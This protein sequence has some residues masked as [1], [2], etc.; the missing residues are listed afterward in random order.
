MEL[1]GVDWLW[2]Y[3]VEIW[4]P[5]E[6]R[7]FLRRFRGSSYVLIV[8]VRENRR[9]C[10]LEQAGGL[11]EDEDKTIDLS[12][13]AYTKTKVRGFS[14]DFIPAH[15]VL[16][17]GSE[18]ITLGLCNLNDNLLPLSTRGFRGYGD[19]FS[20]KR[21]SQQEKPEKFSGDD[22]T[23]IVQSKRKEVKRSGE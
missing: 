20:E 12:F 15:V 7:Q 2:D 17:N 22:M 3:L 10:F 13:I 11:L 9:R 18:S 5:K 19:G 8:E 14:E 6:N 23:H 16:P 4:V 21:W 1:G